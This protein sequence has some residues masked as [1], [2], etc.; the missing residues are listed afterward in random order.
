MNEARIGCKATRNGRRG[1]VKGYPLLALCAA[2]LATPAAVAQMPRPATASPPQ[3]NSSAPAPTQQVPLPQWFLEI[4]TTKKGEVSRA[5]FLEYR[6]KSFAELDANKDGKLSLDEFLKVAE[7]PFSSDVPNGPAL[8]ER[9]NRAKAEFTNLDANRDGVLERVEAEALVNAEFDQYAM[10]GDN[11]VTEAQMRLIVQRSLAREA[12][13]RQQLETRRRQGM[14]AINDFIDMQLREADKLDT[15][16]DGRVNAQEYLVLAGPKNGPQAEGL[17]AYDIRRQLVMRKFQEIDDN[18]DS[19]L[20]RREMVRHAIEQFVE[21]DANKDRFLT[22]EEFKK[23][24]ELEAA[25]MRALIAQ[26]GKPAPAGQTPRASSPPPAGSPPAGRSVRAV[27]SLEK[28]VKA[29][30]V[31]D[32]ETA[33]KEGR[34]L[35]DERDPRAQFLLGL[36]VY[37]NPESKYYDVS[38]ATPLLL[39]AAECG[40]VPAML[41]IAGAYAEGKGVPKS[42][43]EA[44]KWVAIAER[45]HAA[46]A[47]EAYEA[48]ARELKPQEIER[49]KAAALAYTFKTN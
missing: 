34:S 26:M 20:D 24:Q 21:I 4:D 1:C 40:Y 37:G 43:F 11:K 16:Q 22:D 36:Y 44:Y 33:E 15:D 30:E 32:I 47:P 46:V 10:N 7:P 42:A 2:L 25:K 23:A 48:L 35:A 49:A 17:L 19:F 14:A 8:D 38:K 28:A 12:A 6:M 29:M 13:E 5:D 31:G 45:W 41:P 18:K 39:D 9:R 3:T 27:G